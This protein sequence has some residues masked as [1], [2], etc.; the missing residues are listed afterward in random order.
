VAGRMDSFR[1]AQLDLGGRPAGFGR[2]AG[3]IWGV[4]QPVLGGRPTGFGG[5]AGRVG[6]AASRSPLTAQ[7]PLSGTVPTLRLYEMGGLNC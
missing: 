2:S 7:P 4:G 5:S 3:R 6:R 1:A